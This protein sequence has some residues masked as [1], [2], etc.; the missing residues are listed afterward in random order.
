MHMVNLRQ[1]CVGATLL[2]GPQR[3]VNPSTA[4]TLLIA[5]TE[6]SCR[7]SPRRSRASTEA[8][9]DHLDLELLRL[10]T[11]EVGPDVV[12]AVQLTPQLDDSCARSLA[13]Q[14]LVDGIGKV[15][16]WPRGL[17]FRGFR[18]H[19]APQSAGQIRWKPC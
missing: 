14:D 4:A 12:F 17:R 7:V 18:L 5:E 1:P 16:E 9:P 2:L 11:A 8:I 3:A 6:H 15:P 19:F 10:K 13:G